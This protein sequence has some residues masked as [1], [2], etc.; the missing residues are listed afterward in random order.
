MVM[1]KWFAW[2]TV[3]YYVNDNV[4]HVQL[5]AHGILY[6]NPI[7]I[8]MWER[9]KEGEGVWVEEFKGVER[10]VS[11]HE[12]REGDIEGWEVERERERGGG[13]G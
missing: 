7:F 3:L 10:G 12:E 8:Q 11:D 1:Y 5:H 13:G 2:L 4:L 9:E 6:S